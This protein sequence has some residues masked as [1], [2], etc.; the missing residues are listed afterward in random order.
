[1]ATSQAN[2]NSTTMAR[3]RLIDD[4]VGSTS[5]SQNNDEALTSTSTPSAR[6]QLLELEVAGST[7]TRLD[8]EVA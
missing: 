2:T 6:L 4:D 8:L 7:T 1:M 3:R 5:A